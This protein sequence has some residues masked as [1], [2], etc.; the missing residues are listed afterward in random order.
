[1]ILPSRLD[2]HL[3]EHEIQRDGLEIEIALAAKLG[4]HRQEIVASRHLQPMASVKKHRRIGIGQSVEKARTFSSKAGL[5]R[6]S[7]R[8]TSKPNLLS[9]LAVS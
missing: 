8:I 3:L 2:F 1:M 5:V 7:P 9:T 6:S 4:V